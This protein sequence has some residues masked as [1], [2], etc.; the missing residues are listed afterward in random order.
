MKRRVILSLSLGDL[1]TK[2]R[3]TPKS[4]NFWMIG[5]FAGLERVD[6]R[7]R[8]KVG[9]PALALASTMNFPM[10]PVP[11]M[12]KILVVAMAIGNCSG[13][14]K[15]REQNDVIETTT[16][17]QLRMEWILSRLLPAFI[18]NAFFYQPSIW[19]DDYTEV[20]WLEWHYL[21]C[22]ILIKIMSPMFE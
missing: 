10:V 8:A 4:L 18:D 7:T 22:K 15:M 11:P 6:S 16:L 19:I 14:K 12:T 17:V 13:K 21:K 9:W 2:T 20:A 1:R 3:L 5:D